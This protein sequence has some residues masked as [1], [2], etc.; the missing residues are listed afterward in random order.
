MAENPYWK[1]LLAISTAASDQTKGSGGEPRVLDEEVISSYF[2]P[3]TKI[4]EQKM[5]RTSHVRLG[6]RHG[7]SCPAGQCNEESPLLCGR[8]DSSQGGR[9]GQSGSNYTYFFL[10]KIWFV[11]LGKPLTNFK[12]EYRPPKASFHDRQHPK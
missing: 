10:W 11:A 3:K 12:S 5:A 8:C 2:S 4:L 6:E 7:S 1:S 9:S